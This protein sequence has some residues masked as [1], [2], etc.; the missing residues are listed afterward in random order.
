MANNRIELPTNIFL[1]YTNL[2]IYCKY[3]K[4][5]EPFEIALARFSSEILN[6]LE[7]GRDG[8][9]L[10]LA[11]AV[12]KI[13]DLKCFYGKITSEIRKHNPD[14]ISFNS[15]NE[16]AACFRF[17]VNV[18]PEHCSEGIQK[19]ISEHLKK[20]F[21]GELTER[22]EFG[23]H[24]TLSEKASWVNNFADTTWYFYYHE[25]ENSPKTRL[26]IIS[27]LVL[28]IVSPN[29]VFL[30]EKSGISDF[31]GSIDLKSSTQSIVFINLES[32]YTN[33]EFKKL[34]L[35]I[36]PMVGVSDRS[37]FLGQY[38]DGETGNKIVSGTFVMENIK[39]HAV[40][41]PIEWNQPEDEFTRIRE[42]KTHKGETVKVV[43]VD[44]VYHS[45]WERFIPESIAIFLAHKGKNHT[46][47]N[48][49]I[50]DHESL[51]DFLKD[52]R[53]KPEKYNTKIEYDILIV[54]PIGN[55]NEIS[56]RSYYEEINQAFFKYSEPLVS[57]K[58]GKEEQ[59]Q[60]FYASDLLRKSKINRIYYTPR[61]ALATGQIDGD[62]DS[63][64]IINNEI[65]AMKSSRAIV[66]I[67]P[68]LDIVNTSFFI[69]IGWAMNIDRPIIIFPLEKDLL[70]RLIDK[71]H[72]G[73]SFW[74]SS[75]ISI[76][77]IPGR[78]AADYA[79]V[80]HM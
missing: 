35:R 28:E 40:S 26:T 63:E 11:T 37:V 34:Q 42:V 49:K 79:K 72:I 36:L 39:D 22:T 38:I 15:S 29:Q 12:N 45:G 14:I 57:S 27:R 32:R 9:L 65:S 24:Q 13:D 55:I 25:Y 58:N 67:L 33:I 56:E 51:N 54:T 64:T 59:S 50:S 68:K 20:A 46:K 52:Q 75:P 73:K 70:P 77:Q 8:Y 23:Q 18:Y 60:I 76:A 2:V 62:V 71:H 21:G 74:I 7:V 47:I 53:G 5:H 10:D 78:I 4:K 17:I 41:V 43:R 48:P 61:V 69:K 80:L 30:Y 1:L 66:F 44:L 19:F 6:E 16:I 31:V 3:E